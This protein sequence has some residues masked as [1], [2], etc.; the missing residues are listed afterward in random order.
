MRPP[1]YKYHMGKVRLKIETVSAC[2]VG[3]SSP[4]TPLHF[5][6]EG[7]KMHILKDEKNRFANSI[8]AQSV[9]KN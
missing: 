5:M 8:V 6:A 4:L 2:V 3:K 7:R 9:G 1:E